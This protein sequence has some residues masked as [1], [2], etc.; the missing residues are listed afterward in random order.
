VVKQDMTSFH[1]TIWRCL[2]KTTSL[3]SCNF[4]CVFS[5]V[6]VFFRRHEVGHTSKTAY[7]YVTTEC[8][9]HEGFPVLDVI[10]LFY[11]VR[12]INSVM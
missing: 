3:K 4:F 12:P 6:N 11:S 9:M 5:S 10:V 2:N 8:A 1:V 7:E